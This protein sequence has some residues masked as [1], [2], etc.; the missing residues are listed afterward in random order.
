MQEYES[1]VQ[2]PE[3]GH[4]FSFHLLSKGDEAIIICVE[5]HKEL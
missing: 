4:H 2:D 3:L 5:L 1:L